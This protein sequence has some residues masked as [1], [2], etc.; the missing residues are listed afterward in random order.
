VARLGETR[1]ADEDA[2]PGDAAAAGAEGDGA[3]LPGELAGG[4]QVGV[5]PGDVPHVV[6]GDAL[7]AHRPAAQQPLVARHMMH[8]AASEAPGR[9]MPTAASDPSVCKSVV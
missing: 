4:H 5:Q 9:L 6:E 3:A 1:G 8:G 2:C 7:R